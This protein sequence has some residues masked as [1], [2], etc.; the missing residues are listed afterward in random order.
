MSNIGEFIRR[1]ILPHP[2]W[3]AG[4]EG[5]NGTNSLLNTITSTEEQMGS[6]EDYFNFLLSSLCV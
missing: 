2:F 5:L 3:L 4:D 1:K 6:P